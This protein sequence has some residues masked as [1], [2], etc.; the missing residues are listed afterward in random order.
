VSI[1]QELRYATRSLAKSPGFTLIT[2]GILTLGIGANATIFTLLDHLLLQPPPG[3]GEPDSLVRA[4]RFSK[5]RPSEWWSYPDYAFFRDR[6]RAFQG[7][8]AYSPVPLVLQASTRDQPIRA[9][10]SLVSTNFFQVLAVRPTGRGFLE[11]EAGV[12]GEQAVAVLSHGFWKRAFAGSEEAVGSALRLNGHPFTIVGVAPPEFRGVSPVEEAPDLWVP[13]TVRP[14]LMPETGSGWFDRVEGREVTWLQVLGRLRP[15]VPFSSAQLEME[16]LARDFS[17]EYSAF[18]REG[19]GILL[20]RSF[21]LRADEYDQISRLGAL[22]MAV[23]ALVLLIASANVAILLLARAAARRKDF[24]IRLSLGASRGRIAR[25]LLTEGFVL[26]VAGAAGGY[27]IARW[28]VGLTARLLPFTFAFP[29]SPNIRVLAFTIGVAAASAVLSAVAP[30]LRAARTDVSSMIKTGD[31]GSGRT[32]L[33][34]ALVAIQIS[35][36]ILLITGAALFLRSFRAAEEVDLGFETEGRLLVSVDLSQHGYGEEELSRFVD[37]VLGRLSA[38]PGVRAASTTLFAPF[39]GMWGAEVA[40]AEGQKIG[41]SLNA[42]GPGYFEAMGIPLLAGEGF[43]LRDRSGAPRVAIVNQAAAEKLW[44]GENPLGRVIDLG[45]DARTV[46]GVARNAR[47]HELG[48]SPVPHVYLPTLQAHPKEVMFLIRTGTDPW[49][50]AGSAEREI[51]SIAPQVAIA[52]AETLEGAVDRV[53]GRYRTSATLVTLFA[54][55]ALGLSAAGLYGVMSYLVIQRKRAIG[56]QMALGA[57]AQRIVRSVLARSLRVTG[58]G[59]VVG[60]G[61]AWATSRS[62]SSFLFGVSPRDPVTFLLVPLIL[63]AVACLASS[64]PALRASR[65]DPVEVLR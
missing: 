27:L 43:T 17:R 19:Q 15:G 2:I 47:Y 20:S 54:L 9:K 34:E 38:L 28:S 24:G 60:L 8:A 21:Q 31:P 10:A 32:R 1:V 63:G 59:I 4:S 56:V 30:A 53:L 44:P 40:G 18:A 42:I 25:Q 23:V 52:G 12:P 49:A 37:Q 6:S 3:I 36:S 13:L 48:E 58:I 50:V 33:L 62:I 51:Q 26:A 16:A 45:K 46:V 5:D 41:A 7:L 22:L 64:I 14:M 39:G 29:F 65:V 61:M 11:E 55:V 57:T 35:L